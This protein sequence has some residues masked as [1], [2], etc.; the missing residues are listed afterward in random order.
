M[1]RILQVKQHGS[2]TTKHLVLGARSKLQTTIG[3]FHPNHV[4]AQ[5]C[6]Q[7]RR[8]RTGPDPR[9]LNYPQPHQRP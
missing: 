2:P 8:M 6:Q 3:P 9:Q 7:H 1:S 4:S 5:I